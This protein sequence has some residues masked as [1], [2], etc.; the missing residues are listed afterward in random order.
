MNWYSIKKLAMPLMPTTLG[1]P[2]GLGYLDIGHDHL[3]GIKTYSEEGL[4]AMDYDFKIFTIKIKNNN[5]NETHT[6]YGFNNVEKYCAKGRYSFKPDKKTEISL[7]YLFLNKMDIFEW[8]AKRKEYLANK[9]IK[10]L[11]NHFVSPKIYSNS[12]IFEG[13]NW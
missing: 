1:K 13:L 6:S 4:W 5:R 7:V 3:Q 2:N 10:S 12:N 9:I 11:D 8:S